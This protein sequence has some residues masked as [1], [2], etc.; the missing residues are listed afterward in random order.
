[1]TLQTADT[2][3]VTRRAEAATCGLSRF[4]TGKPCKAGHL[5]E[6]YVS[7]RQC[8]SCNAKSA[9]LREAT[10]ARSDPSYRMYRNAQ[11]RAGQALK[12]AASPIRSLACT[13]PELRAFIE[14]QF[15]PGMSWAT[16]GQWELD[17]IRPLSAARTTDER[18]ALCNHTNLQPLW[19]REN[20]MKGGA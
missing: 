9:R 1:M 18:F 20:L 3:I 11:R 16:Y 8:V 17:H 10:R 12:G 15:R 4:Y 14:R 5:A 19:K 7:N 6:R 2:L 13:A